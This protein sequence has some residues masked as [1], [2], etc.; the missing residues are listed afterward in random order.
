MRIF[1]TGGTGFI[2]SHLVRRLVA[3]GHEVRCLVRLGRKTRLLDELSVQQVPG[4]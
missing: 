3:E 1:V 4:D 2:G